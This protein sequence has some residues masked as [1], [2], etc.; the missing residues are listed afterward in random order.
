[1]MSGP[2]V[3]PYRPQDAR[4]R[5]SDARVY[6]KRYVP[7]HLRLEQVPHPPRT[8]LASRQ[9]G[10]WARGRSAREWTRALVEVPLVKVV[11]PSTL[12][13]TKVAASID[14]RC[15]PTAATES[16]C[17]FFLVETPGAPCQACDL[18]QSSRP[19]QCAAVVDMST[20]ADPA[21]SWPT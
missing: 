4:C 12:S 2:G 14:S 6:E 5:R 11:V 10:A 19:D 7:G 18:K 21:P 1:M 13:V 20:V 9:L 8:P 3:E 17:P 16:E 15:R